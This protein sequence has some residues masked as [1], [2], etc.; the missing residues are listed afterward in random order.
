MHRSVLLRTFT[1]AL[2][3]A[4]VAAGSRAT[5][6]PDDTRADR[7]RI[8]A[9][10]LR[11][12]PVADLEAWLLPPA[13]PELRRQA[14]RAL[15]R[16]GAA[17][18]PRL[19]SLLESEDGADR[20]LVLWSAGLAM[21]KDLAPAI[22]AHVRDPDPAVRAAAAA[23]LGWCDDRGLLDDLGELLLDP[24]PAVRAGALTGLA[25]SGQEGTLERVLVLLRDPAIEVRDAAWHAAWRTAARRAQ[26]AKKLNPEWPGDSL[27][28]ARLLALHGADATRRV[29]LVRVLAN[30][31]PPSA[32]LPVPEDDARLQQLLAPRAG[33][34]RGDQE[35][36]W[37]ILGPRSGEAVEAL[38]NRYLLAEDMITRGQAYEVLAASKAPDRDARLVEAQGRERDARLADALARALAA[39][40]DAGASSGTLPSPL[41]PLTVDRPQDVVTREVTD[42]LI[43]W[44]KGDAGPT[45]ETWCV[46]AALKGLFE[47]ASWMAVFEEASRRA[48]DEPG[49]APWLATFLTSAPLRAQRPYLVA[50]ALGLVEAVH[51]DA[52]D[53]AVR[54]LVPGDEAGA[55]ALDPE[56][57]RALVGALAARFA[58]TEGEARAPFEHDLRTLATRGRSAFSRIA[59]REALA[60]ADITIEAPLG[61]LNDWRGLPR[62]ATPLPAWGLTGTGPW[63]DEVEILQVADWIA[64]TGARVVFETKWGEI[65]LSLDPTNAPVHSAALVLSAHAGLY[66]T[67]RWHRVVPGFVLQG[68]DPRGHGAGNAGWTIPD[69]IT[70]TS[71]ARGVLGMPKSVKD[72]GGCQV[73]IMLGDYKPLDERY[74]A[75]GRVE[76]SMIAVDTLRV[77]GRILGCRLEVPAR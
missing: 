39:S 57:E 31:L 42:L 45:L 9:I 27:M 21:S 23:A 4:C 10:E 51:D 53:A 36:L 17:A 43:G 58:A 12:G 16:I 33:D 24:V 6:A 38:V 20:A 14:I 68:G 71:F 30:L 28:S 13:S 15:G 8:L 49:L 48:K 65:A 59:A 77:G 37:R 54:A 74:T 7:A 5:A 11:R 40:R 3:L 63:L 35:V 67:G 18:A 72:D 46:G 2:V 29:D 69:E 60:K 75:Y 55:A 66:A 26:A 70:P 22:R 76:G 1:T 64:A 41:R 62:P 56:I 73:F 34:D 61:A 32:S 47:E 19:K 25:R 50:F 44:T 52:V